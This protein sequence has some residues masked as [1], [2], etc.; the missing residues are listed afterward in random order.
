MG[1]SQLSTHR[2]LQKRRVN[3]GLGCK[4]A[5]NTAVNLHMVFNLDSYQYFN[6]LV[7]GKWLVGT[8]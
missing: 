8:M 5:C 7:Q 6:A 1:V 3:C 2:K 4:L